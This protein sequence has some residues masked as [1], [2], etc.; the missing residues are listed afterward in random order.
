MNLGVFLIR[1]IFVIFDALG[2]CGYLA[3]LDSDVFKDSWLYS[4][5]L[6]AIGL[7][8]IYRRIVWQT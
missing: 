5:T 8:V 2:S 1:R 6:T 4:I 7:V 3:H